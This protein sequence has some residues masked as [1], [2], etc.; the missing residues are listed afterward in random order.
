MGLIGR[1]IAAVQGDEILDVGGNRCPPVGRGICEDLVVGQS[2]QGWIGYNRGD[3]VAL[4][5]ELLGDVITKHLVQQQRLAHG[6]PGQKLAL[7]QPGALSGFLGC[8]GG[9]NLRVDLI[10]VGSPVADRG[11]YQARFYT[12][13]IAD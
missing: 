8:V 6:L 5:A 1:A 4:G 3:V 10:G 11:R 13:V 7:A 2:Y 12:S 9:G